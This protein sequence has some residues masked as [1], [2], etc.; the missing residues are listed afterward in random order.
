MS[1][2]FSMRMLGTIPEGVVSRWSYTYVRVLLKRDILDWAN[3]WLNGTLLWRVWLRGAVE[4]SLD[5]ANA[6]HPQ[7]RRAMN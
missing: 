3:D 2:C 4:E 6:S 1:R 7:I 5:R